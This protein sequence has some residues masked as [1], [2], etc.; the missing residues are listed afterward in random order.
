MKN[1]ATVVR[2]SSLVF[3]WILFFGTLIIL[4]FS[5]CMHHSEQQSE[6]R[7]NLMIP[8]EDMFKVIYTSYDILCGV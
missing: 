7:D 5:S 3:P 1:K 6:S 4:L 8:Q 2:K